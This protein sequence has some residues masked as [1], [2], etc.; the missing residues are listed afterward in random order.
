MSNFRCAR[1]G[2]F[3]AVMGLALAPFQAAWAQVAPGTI[4]DGESIF[5]D[6]Q[7]FKI[8][9]GQAKPAAAAPIRD[10]GGRDLG[11]GAIIYRF[12]DRLYILGAPLTLE[13]GRQGTPG[14]RVVDAD[15]E[16]L[17]RIRIE[18]D[19]PK[20]LEHQKL[21]QHLRQ[22]QVLETIQE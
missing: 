14:S 22:N 16:Q 15:R 8:A 3:A 9:P 2:L 1:R 7:T 18:Y 20:N 5:I 12:G 21:Y 19:A 17:G 6:G 13:R 10:L 4:A 11:P